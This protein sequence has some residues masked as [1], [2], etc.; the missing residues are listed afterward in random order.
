[1]IILEA[2]RIDGERFSYAV[3]VVG[4]KP[5]LTFD[6][7]AAERVLTRQGVVDAKRLI[8]QAR[9]W[10]AVEIHEHAASGEME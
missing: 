9:Q 2:K 10:G 3:Q 8:E 4:R 7:E 1:M 5:F 6:A